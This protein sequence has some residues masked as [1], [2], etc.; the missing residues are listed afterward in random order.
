MSLPGTWMDQARAESGR[1]VTVSKKSQKQTARKGGD[2]DL[3]KWCQGMLE[4]E[5]HLVRPQ[6]SLGT[7]AASTLH[8]FLLHL[9]PALSLYKCTVGVFKKKPFSN[10]ESKIHAFSG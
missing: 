3:A 8:P 4:L 5:V 7:A 2:H 6:L 9:S 10:A 1:S